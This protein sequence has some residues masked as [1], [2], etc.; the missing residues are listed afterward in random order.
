[1]KLYLFDE[2]YPN[3]L[4]FQSL[5]L[6]LPWIFL[7]LGFFEALMMIGTITAAWQMLNSLDKGMSGLL[8]NSVSFE[9]LKE[10]GETVRHF[11]DFILPR[12][13][14]NFST[15]SAIAD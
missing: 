1:M 6:S 7:N 9:F 15:I 4:D 3:L 10:K 12:Y 5:K 14:A 13:L 8:N 2:Y 11:L